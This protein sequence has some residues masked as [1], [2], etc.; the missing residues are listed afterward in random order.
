MT[1]QGRLERQVVG[2]VETQVGEEERKSGLAEGFE[3]DLRWRAFQQRSREIPIRV[4]LG[5]IELAVE[6]LIAQASQ[7]IAHQDVEVGHALAA[8]GP[9]PQ[10][11]ADLAD[12][13]A[14]KIGWREAV[15]AAALDRL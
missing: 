1:A 14:M 9:R 10:G 15:F 12:R 13:L 6:K 4:E 11:G 5:R 3:D 8:H 7:G 2:V